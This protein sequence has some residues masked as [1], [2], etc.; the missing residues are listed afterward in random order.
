MANLVGNIF[1]VSYIYTE[2]MTRGRDIGL[3]AVLLAIL[4]R[5]M[6][7]KFFLM[8]CVVLNIAVMTALA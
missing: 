7:R 4:D 1:V 8:R 5:V 6:V 2:D 3:C